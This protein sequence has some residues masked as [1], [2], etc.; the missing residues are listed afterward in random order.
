M[1]MAELSAAA[2]AAMVAH[3]AELAAAAAALAQLMLV[4]AGFR[5]IVHPA[6]GVPV[7]HRVE[8]RAETPVS[9]PVH[10]LPVATV[11]LLL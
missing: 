7:G 11:H 4:T 3:I 10:L 2:M 1:A 9:R 8:V 6:L 5:V